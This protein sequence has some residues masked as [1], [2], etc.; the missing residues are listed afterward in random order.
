[1]AVR[2][3]VKSG[4]KA[5][6]LA[7]GG[8]TRLYPLT[9][10]IA[11]PMVPVLNR[12]VLEHIIALL[13]R[14]GITELIANL[15][16]FPEQIVSYF[17]DG[18]RC[19]V[20]LEYSHER[21]LLGTAGGVKHVA[22]FFGDQTFI[23]IGGDDLADF[24]L[25]AM[26]AFHRARNAMAT[27]AVSE[28]EHVTE[29]GIVVSDDD[30]RIRSFQEKPAAH[31]ALSRTANTG[32]YMFEP[33]LLDYIP[34]NE[35]F[36]FGKQVFPLLLKRGAPFYA[37]RAAGYWKDIGNPREYLDA[38]I[39][40]L[41]GKAGI[42]PAGVEISPGVWADDSLELE[43]AHLEPPAALG[44]GCRL[45]SGCRVGTCVIGPRARVA[46]GAKLKGCVV[47]EET[48]TPAVSARAATF[49]PGRVVLA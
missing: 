31:E 3:R 33:A 14:H 13:A 15:H 48:E 30:G 37:W 28:V 29:Y 42:A 6:V 24:D 7:A 49:A 41:E 47:W 9:F 40:A 21:E 19:G 23:V 46:A 36:D 25:T 39:D 12:P 34:A 26:A 1:M 5:M 10:A 35:F 22:S 27:I 45:E 16:S 17:G 8:G 32:V 2:P 11:K 44:A 43:G 4:I 38:N 18:A 20:S